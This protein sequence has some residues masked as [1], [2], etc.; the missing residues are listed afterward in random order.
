MRL[1]DGFNQ[2]YGALTGIMALLLWANLTGIALFFGL[3]FA[4]QLE[5]LRVGAPE[6]AEPDIWKPRPPGDR[7]A[8]H[9]R[10]VRALTPV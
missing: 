9:G 3:A 7:A 10:D 2:T 4:A 8:R 5:G 1:S 6:P